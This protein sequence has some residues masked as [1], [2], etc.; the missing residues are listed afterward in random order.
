MK[1]E[2]KGK[3]GRWFVVGGL[4]LLISIASVGYLQ[5]FDLTAAE[6]DW[7]TYMREEEKLARDV[8]LFL[9]DKWQLPIF[10]NISKSEQ[11]HMDAIKTLLLRYGIP[12]PAEGNLRGVFTNPDLQNLYDDLVAQGSV[13]P[14]EALKVGEF[15]EETDIADLN[16]ATA[17]T[18]RKDI[19]TVYGNLLQGSLNHL[20]AFVANL[21]SYGI[22]YQP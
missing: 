17:S 13:S 18:S 10:A 14:A 19:K 15:I 8:Y 1:K 16:A 7:L 4:L 12:D 11:T 21:A 6:K 3:A 5:A 20:K 2:F 22:T 9:Y